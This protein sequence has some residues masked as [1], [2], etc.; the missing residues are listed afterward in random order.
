MNKYIEKQAAIEA[1]N[2]ELEGINEVLTSITLPYHDKERQR[3]RKGQVKEDIRA[4][5]SVPSADVAPVRHGWWVGYPE[6]LKYTNAYSD[7][8]IVCSVCEECYSIL[9]NDCG[10]FNYCPNCGARM[11]GKQDG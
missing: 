8:H 4:I 2:K 5:E 7:D 3:Q 1:L 11:D 10:R 9:D 6:C